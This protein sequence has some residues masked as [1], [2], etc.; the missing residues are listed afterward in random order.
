MNLNND[1]ASTLPIFSISPVLLRGKCNGKVSLVTTNPIA[2]PKID[3]NYLCDPD[4]MEWTRQM[5]LD[6]SRIIDELA[7]NDSRYQAVY[8]TKDMIEND[9]VLQTV[10]S[11]FTS[12]YSHP[13][14]SCRMAPRDDTNRGVINGNLCVYGIQNVRV[15]DASIFFTPPS[16]NPQAPIYALAGLAADII[17]STKCS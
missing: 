9:Q 6:I 14:G 8:P 11:S 2:Y 7:K 15:A 10:I 16:G 13:T 5:F 3:H 1:L 4:D 17:K 12:G